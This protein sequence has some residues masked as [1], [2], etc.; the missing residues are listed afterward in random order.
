MR[1]FPPGHNAI[2]D[3]W[4]LLLDRFGAGGR[5]H[6][7]VAPLGPFLDPGCRA[8]EQPEFGY[9]RFCRT[10][11]DHRQAFLHAGWHKILSYETD[12]MT[13]DE[14]VRATY[15]VAERLN[16]LKHRYRL[17]DDRTFADVRF[18]LKIARQIVANAG[19]DEV[20][21]PVAEL[22]NCR[23]MFGDDELKWPVKRR[24]RVGTT[25]LRNL[26][27]GLALEFRHTAARL[28]GHYDVAPA[29]EVAR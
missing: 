25:L 28:V 23:T 19:E 24:F 14:I 20:S 22:A 21:G 7:F 15:D 8:F 11:D 12:G 13:R 26:A 10:L 17:I 3:Y 27:A 18:R 9:T 1:S 4:E 29:R 5:L 2:A 16:D 6:P